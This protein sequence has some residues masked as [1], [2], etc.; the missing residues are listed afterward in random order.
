MGGSD[1]EGSKDTRTGEG[2]YADI[3][4]SLDLYLWTQFKTILL[5]Y[6]RNYFISGETRKV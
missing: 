5:Y 6:Q 1:N 4:I 2:G 3:A